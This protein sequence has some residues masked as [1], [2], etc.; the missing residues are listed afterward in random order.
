MSTRR[1]PNSGDPRRETTY[2]PTGVV[3][4][5]EGHRNR[6]PV[7]V[8]GQHCWVTVGMWGIADPAAGTGLLD[9]ENLLTLDGPACFWCMQQWSQELAGTPCEGESS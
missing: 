4:K 6:P 5:V 3:L 8:R 9:A 1:R 2:R 7:M